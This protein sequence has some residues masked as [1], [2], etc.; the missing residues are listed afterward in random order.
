MPMAVVANVLPKRAH[1]LIL[2]NVLQDNI[3]GFVKKICY[4]TEVFA[5]ALANHNS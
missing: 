1:K 2:F 4:A 3:Q 5:A